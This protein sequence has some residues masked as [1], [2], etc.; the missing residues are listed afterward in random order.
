MCW[1]VD[2]N[3]E[4]NIP[5]VC[6]PGSGNPACWPV[7]INKKKNTSPVCFPGSGNPACWPVNTKTDTVSEEKPKETNPQN[8]PP[9]IDKFKEINKSDFPKEDM[10]PT[11]TSQPS[12]SSELTTNTPFVNINI[13]GK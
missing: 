13:P 11:F 9:I 8:P 6:I 5:P 12:F 4:K 7:D 10:V 2:I 1:P 3:K